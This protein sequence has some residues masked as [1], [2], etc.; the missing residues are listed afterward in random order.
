MS[1]FLATKLYVAREIEMGSSSKTTAFSGGERRVVQLDSVKSK[2][3]Q[4][5]LSV[6]Q[7]MSSPKPKVATG[8]GPAIDQAWETF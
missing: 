6:A 4:K 3:K 8:T 2:L 7:T 1:Q 5:R